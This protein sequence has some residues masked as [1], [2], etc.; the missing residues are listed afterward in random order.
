M[1]ELTELALDLDQELIDKMN[2]VDGYDFD[3]Y[4][5]KK[6]ERDIDIEDLNDAYLAAIRGW[7][8]A[9]HLRV[10][11]DKVFEELWH[12]HFEFDLVGFTNYID[13]LYLDIKAFVKEREQDKWK[14]L[15]GVDLTPFQLYYYTLLYALLLLLLW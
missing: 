12:D 2:Y 3:R 14:P 6:T 4:I 9:D 13:E 7:T 8:Y 1:N 15:Q 10:E 5:T 11:L